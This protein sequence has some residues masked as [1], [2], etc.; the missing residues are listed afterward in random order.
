[1]NC[2]KYVLSQG[3][4]EPAD[5]YRCFIEAVGAGHPAQLE[6]TRPTTEGDPIPVSYAG[7][8]SGEVERITD[9]RQDAFGTRTMTREVCSG[10]AVLRGLLTF[11]HC[12]PAG[13]VG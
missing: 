9:S 1:V 8:A 7:H 6:V 4:T 13:P 2:G 11:A 12:G 5:A 3:E 10:P